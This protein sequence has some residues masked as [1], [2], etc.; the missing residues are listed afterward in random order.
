MPL[1]H[2]IY[3]Y[4]NSSQVF[5]VALQESRAR[6]KYFLALGMQIGSSLGKQGKKNISV[7]ENGIDTPDG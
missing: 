6:L 5:S 4:I 2:I 1:F 7:S 3:I